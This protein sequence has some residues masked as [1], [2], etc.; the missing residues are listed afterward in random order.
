MSDTIVKAV[1]E[2]VG[3]LD[4]AFDNEIL[5]HVNVAAYD[6]FQNGV[7]KG[8]AITKDTTMDDLA[9]NPDDTEAVKSYFTLT[10]KLLLDSPQPSMVNTYTA[11]LSRISD[12]LHLSRYYKEV[13]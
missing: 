10:V 3:F 12:R 7:I 4:E 5:I 11:T 2:G 13:K 8:Q 6:L 1:R 9:P